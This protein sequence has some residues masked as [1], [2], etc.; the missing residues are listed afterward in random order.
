M[1]LLNREPTLTEHPR[2]STLGYF[3]Q[4]GSRTRR[5]IPND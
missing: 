4:P 1:I 3:Q 2:N 5:A